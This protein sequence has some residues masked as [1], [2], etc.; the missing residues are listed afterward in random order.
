MTLRDRDSNPKFDIQS[1]ACCQLHH[2]GS[3]EKDSRHGTGAR[4]TESPGR[5]RAATSRGAAS[6]PRLAAV[7]PVGREE[8][9]D[10]VLE[11]GVEHEQDL[12]AGFDHG[13]GLGDEAGPFA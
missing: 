10:R 7:A 9:R 6:E 1:V 13:V 4:A 11:A 8:L 12:V 5:R 2:P 3:H